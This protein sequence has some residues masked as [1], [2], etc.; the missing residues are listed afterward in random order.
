MPD[1]NNS[2]NDNNNN[3]KTYRKSPNLIRYS[4]SMTFRLK[5]S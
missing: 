4:S 2:D 1:H 3:G 5:P